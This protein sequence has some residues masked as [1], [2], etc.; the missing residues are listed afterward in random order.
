LNT[1]QGRLPT[2]LTECSILVFRYD[3]ANSGLVLCFYC[4]CVYNW[5]I[6]QPWTKGYLKL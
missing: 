4:N 3:T 5:T 1:C 2:P 6:E